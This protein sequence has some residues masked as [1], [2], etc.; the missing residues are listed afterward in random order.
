MAG[1]ATRRA[2]SAPSPGPCQR[3]HPPAASTA[4]TSTPS[5]APAPAPTPTPA[6]AQPQ[7][8]AAAAA[9][10][11]DLES[12][13]VSSGSLFG[14]ALQPLL[15]TAGPIRDTDFHLSAWLHVLDIE[16]SSTEGLT[17]VTPPAATALTVLTAAYIDKFV[18]VCGTS[19]AAE[20]AVSAFSNGTL[21]RLVT[22]DGAPL[23][24]PRSDA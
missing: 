22:S 6:P 23:L 8:A 19:V 14:Q 7:A 3:S 21:A 18:T 4:D 1:A 16:C 11:T 12:A 2:C 13:V 15:A 5:P 20:N 10:L 9:S 17:V 24:P